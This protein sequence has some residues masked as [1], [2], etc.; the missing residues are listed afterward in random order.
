MSPG[1]RPLP[2]LV[3]DL[4]SREDARYQ[5]RVNQGAT[6]MARRPKQK[7]LTSIPTQFYP[8]FIERLNGNYA[9][10]Q[11]IRDR[12]TALEAHCGGDIGYVKE[13]LIKR[14]IWLEL[15]TETYEQRFAS[16]Q[17]VDIGALTQLNN[18]L[19]GLYKDLGLKPTERKTDSLGN[20]MAAKSS[21]QPAEAPSAS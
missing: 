7:L 19:K 10:T 18:T 4:R 21:R 6:R 1:C 14:L 11:I 9:M 13:S 5:S 16:G 3:K 12:R 20:Y 8:D 15:I 2:S 17:E